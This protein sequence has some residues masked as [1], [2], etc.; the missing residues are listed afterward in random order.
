MRRAA[1]RPPPPRDPPALSPPARKA[2]SAPPTSGPPAPPRPAPPP[3]PPQRFRHALG[4]PFQPAQ[5]AG[6][7]HRRGL[8]LG[9]A[10]AF[11]LEPLAGP[12]DE[13]GRLRA[14]RAADPVSRLQLL[15]RRERLP[16]AL[17]AALPL[18]F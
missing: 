3:R 5:R 6:P 11:H 4:R 18:D 13:Q 17:P 1:P 7:L 10:T 2:P 14:R 15:Q 8:H 12:D 16:R 9:A